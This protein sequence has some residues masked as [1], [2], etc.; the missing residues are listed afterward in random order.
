MPMDPSEAKLLA[1]R[2]GAGLLD[3][4][5]MYSFAEEATAQG[6]DHPG[7]LEILVC[8]PGA[9]YEEIRPIF[10]RYIKSFGASI[11]PSDVAP[12]A[13][14]YEYAMQARK[15][16]GQAIDAAYL[17]DRDC[18]MPLG[19]V[20][21]SSRLL[22]IAMCA[23]VH[24]AAETDRDKARTQRDSETLADRL[25]EELCADYEAGNLAAWLP[26][27]LKPGSKSKL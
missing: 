20:W 5:E 21:G 17:I 8:G 2:F 10:A 15:G 25:C 9:R 24:G 4:H 19:D 22:D 26:E 18:V 6:D 1:A 7:L 13:L 16:D 11:P 3:R 14:A 23:A 12:V 27:H